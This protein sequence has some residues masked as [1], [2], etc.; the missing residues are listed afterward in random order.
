VLSICSLIISELA[1]TSDRSQFTGRLAGATQII[2]AILISGFSLFQFEPGFL[3]RGVVLIGVFAAP[4]VVGLIGVHSRRPA[5]LL[6]AGLAS[7]LGSF[8]AFSL[9]TLIFL[10]P[11][12]LFLV[13]AV[14][15]AGGNPGSARGGLVGGIAQLALAIAIV[16]LLVG[17]GAAGLL[18]TDSACWTTYGSGLGSRV[19]MQPYTNGEMELPTDATSM[20]CAT[21]LISPQGVGLAVLLDGAAFGLALLATR[22]RSRIAA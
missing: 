7:A 9:V 14:R 19:V 1:V 2:F 21:G 3:P 8:T 12:V 11:S 5:L 6:A 18:I 13:G 4:G 20:N 15:L 10:I 22:R 16:P 17:A